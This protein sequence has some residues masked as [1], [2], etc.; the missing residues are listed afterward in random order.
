MK[1]IFYF[2]IKITS[3]LAILVMMAG[4]CSS[5]GGYTEEGLDTV[6]KEYRESPDLTILLY[7][8]NYEGNKYQHQYQVLLPLPDSTID[9]RVTK[10]YPVSD[11]FFNENID[12]LGMELANKKDGIVNKTVAPAGYSQYVGNPN[13]GRWTERNGS[14]FWEFY[15]Q[16][17][18][19]NSMFHMFSSPARYSYWNDYSRNYAPGGRTYRGPNNYY[20][21]DSYMKSNTGKSTSW[22]KK[23]SSFRSDV[24]SRVQRSSTASKSK[25]SRSSSRYSSSSSSRSR[26]GGFGK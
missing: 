4:G 23:P 24:R 18:F 11:N 21:T 17:A 7:D 6:I 9:A 5:G 20:G 19:M 8:Q 26:S 14:S 2:P 12:N 1:N 10:F 16:F 25:V 22:S 13:Y 15:G 3:I